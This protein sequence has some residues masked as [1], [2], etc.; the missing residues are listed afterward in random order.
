MTTF[1]V[2]VELNRSVEKQL[3]ASMTAFTTRTVEFLASEYGFDAQEAIQRLGLDSVSVSRPM[4][5]KASPKA[6]KVPKEKRLVPSI[7]LPFCGVKKEDWCCGLRLNHGLYS[8]CT[9]PKCN[10]TDFCKTCT[11]QVE[12]NETE[13]PTYGTIQERM[14]IAAMEFRDPKGKAVVC[15]GNVMAKLKISKE[16][17]IAEAAKFDLVISEEQFEERKTTRGRPKKDATATDT[18]SESGDTKKSGGRPKKNKKVI[19]AKATDDLIA[20][21]VA[22]ADLDGSESDSSLKS[23]VSDQ[24]EVSVQSAVSTDSKKAN[25]VKV[26]KPVLTDEEKA[27]KK[28]ATAAKRKATLAAK[29]E[30]TDEEKAAKKAASSAKRTATW[31][32]KK[33]AKEAAD[34]KPE[35]VLGVTVTDVPVVPVVAP[36]V[37]PVAAPVVELVVAP[38]VELVEE[39]VSDDDSDGEMEVTKFEHDGVTYLKADDDILYDSVSQDEVGVWNSVTKQVDFNDTNCEE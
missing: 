14:A 38:V 15:Y 30:L 19:A 36:V 6:P 24:S 9:M 31:A 4:K 35:A 8:Q 26:L 32:A 16:T 11:K 1:D 12:K 18:D 10:D 39:V 29:P 21:L 2:S 3:A 17:A 25:K 33:A 37:A 23:D 5:K 20:S 22:K 27:A 13:K 7:P 34:T 28:A